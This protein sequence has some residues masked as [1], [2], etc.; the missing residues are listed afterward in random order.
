MLLSECVLLL[1]EA[2]GAGPKFLVPLVVES[3]IYQK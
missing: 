2:N 1:P 3:G